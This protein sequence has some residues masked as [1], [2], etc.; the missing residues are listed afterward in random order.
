MY[1]SWYYLFTENLKRIFCNCLLKK[2]KNPTPTIPPPHPAPFLPRFSIYFGSSE[3]CFLYELWPNYRDWKTMFDWDRSLG[4]KRHSGHF[5]IN[6]VRQ[7]WV[8]FF[9]PLTL[10]YKYKKQ[11]HGTFL[12]WLDKKFVFPRSK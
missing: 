8:C 11:D 6:G 2:K 4:E 7:P 9:L 12:N 10:Y 3:F 5:C 1:S